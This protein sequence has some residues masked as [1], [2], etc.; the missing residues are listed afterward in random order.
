M[1][2]SIKFTFKRQP[3]LNFKVTD[4]P[5]TRFTYTEGTPFPVNSGSNQIRY[6]T[7]EEYKDLTGVEST[8]DVLYIVTDYKV[9]DE[10]NTY[11]GLLIG[12]G[13]AY[14]GDLPVL[15]GITANE[16]AA[17]DSIYDKVGCKIDAFDEE[18]I[19]FYK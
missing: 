10:G 11:P 18:L 16:Q 12:D 2:H 19:V 5:S 6:L 8:K 13:N 17:I 7:M 15:V 4:N 9:D 14:I 3:S 1:S